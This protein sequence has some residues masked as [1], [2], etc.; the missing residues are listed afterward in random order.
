MLRNV[1]TLLAAVLLLTALGCGGGEGDGERFAVYHLELALGPAGEEGEL[2]CGPPRLACPGVVAQP[3]PIEVRY[4]VLAEPGLDD[5]SID[6]DEVRAEGSQLSIPLT[7]AGMEA[8]AGLSRE[9]ARYGERDQAWHHLAVVIGD[10]VV[11]FPQVDFDQ[12]PDGFPDSPSLQIAAV[13]E[14][15]AR[16]LVERLRGG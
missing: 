14:A 16:Q 2:R 11:A 8:F 1:R 5:S 6:R 4:E 13:D 12:F 9:V 10:E 15:D 3:A 7:G